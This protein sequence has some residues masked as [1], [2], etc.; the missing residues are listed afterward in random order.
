MP[1]GLRQAGID[2]RQRSPAD[3]VWSVVH[4]SF[5]SFASCARSAATAPRHNSHPARNDGGGDDGARCDRRSS[6][7]F[8]TGQ[9]LLAD[10][11]RFPLPKF[12]ISRCLLQPAG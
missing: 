12:T 10:V 5:P 7:V 8:A 4:G 6:S 3:I 2:H 9:P 1:L 11:G